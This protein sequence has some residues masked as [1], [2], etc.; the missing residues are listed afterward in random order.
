MEPQVTIFTA[1]GCPY[2]KAAKDFLADKGIQY[3]EFDVAADRNAMADMQKLTGG[4]RTVPVLQ[5]CQ[6]VIVGF[7]KDRVSMALNC[8]SHSTQLPDPE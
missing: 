3:R 7:D 4:A 2:C 6:D 5:V 8:L 1:T